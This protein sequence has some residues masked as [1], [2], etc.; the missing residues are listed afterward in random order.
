MNKKLTLKWLLSFILVF[1][2]SLSAHGEDKAVSPF[3]GKWCNKDFN[4]GGVTRVHIRQEGDKL[5][6]HMWGR[7]YPT[8]CDWKESTAK[9]EEG[10]KVLS[11]TWNLNFATVTQKLTL[12]ADGSLS[13]VDHTHYTDKSGR[14]DKNDKYTFAKG[15][16]H[17]WSYPREK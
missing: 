17:D 7:C 11:L 12:L 1:C 10:G 15:L 9:I 16:E 5:I 8:E 3:V 2:A 14:G 4:T 6:A 13:L